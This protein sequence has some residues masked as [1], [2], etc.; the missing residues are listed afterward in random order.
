MSLILADTQPLRGE[1]A[2]TALEAN[3]TSLESKLDELLASFESAA[4]ELPPTKN[5]DA[6]HGPDEKHRASS[7][8]Q[9]DQD[10]AGN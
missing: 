3:L 5:G 4:G 2:A 1:Q 9:N 7:E 8:P 6:H 10:V